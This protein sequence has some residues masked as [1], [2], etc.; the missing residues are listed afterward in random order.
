MSILS[1][2]RR[3]S[4]LSM[5]EIAPGVLLYG[6]SGAGKTHAAVEGGTPLVL[7]LEPNGITTVVRANPAATV[8]PV[9][10]LQELSDAMSAI[11]AG[12]GGDFDRVVIDSVTE[13]SRL[14]IEAVVAAA[15]QDKA[16]IQDWGTY[17][18]KMMGL[19]RRL[20]A[21]PLAVVCIALE[22]S[23]QDE[24]AAFHVHPDLE[25]QKVATHCAQFFSAVGYVVKRYENKEVAHRI[26]WDGPSE[27]VTKSCGERASGIVEADV[28]GFI[29]SFN[30]AANAAT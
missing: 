15:G 12:E 14:M 24:R 1:R 13:A 25:G 3:A 8:L 27:Y 9:R 26:M 22:K 19:F 28:L 21:M 20:R 29:Q 7:S 4:T 5:G 2:A 6:K 17:T 23:T 10:T 30:Q 11:E 16:R 18:A